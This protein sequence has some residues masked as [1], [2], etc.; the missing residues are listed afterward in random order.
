LRIVRSG[1][2][3]PRF[4]DYPT[5]YIYMQAAVI[6]VRF[7]AGAMTGLW[8]SLDQASAGDFYLW[9]RAVTAVIGTVTI[10]IAWAIARRFGLAGAV[11]AA[12]FLAVDPMHTRESRYV[13]TD[14]PQ[15]FLALLACLLS[16]RAIERPS[17]RAFGW[18]GVA[19]GL[20][21]ATKYTAIIGAVMPGIALLLAQGSL[22]QRAL[23]LGWTAAAAAGSFLVAAPY[24]VLDLPGFLNAFAALYQS[25]QQGV[26]DPWRSY[27]TH[28][29]IDLGWPAYVFAWVGVAAGLIRGVRRSDPGH[30]AGAVAVTFVIAYFVFLSRHQLVFGR[31]LLPLV[32][33]LLVLLGGLVGW[34]HDRLRRAGLKPAHAAAASAILVAA[35]AAKPAT[36]TVDFTR[37]ISRPTT[38]G[39]AHEWLLAHAPA[40][41]H[42][43]IESGGLIPAAGRYVVDYYTSLIRRDF[44]YLQARQT[45]FVIASSDAYGRS[46]L[47]SPDSPDAGRYRLLFGRLEPVVTFSPSPER[48]GPELRIFRVPK[49]DVSAR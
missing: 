14:V 21:A 43:A 26:R 45:D 18:A 30:A 22:A 47:E 39:L 20:A 35:L 8:S 10:P 29:R 12:T 25:Y 31:Y 42:L 17:P 33:I 28:L 48:R 44:D 4:F 49:G 13:L 46:L 3:H 32:P 24:T 27:L 38:A 40:G 16:V 2:F 6:V 5:L 19:V 1:D 23:W 15:A 11:V 34:I 7:L 36:S 9:G 37:Q 41:S